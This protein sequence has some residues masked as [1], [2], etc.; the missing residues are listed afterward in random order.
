MSHPPRDPLPS[1]QRRVV[2]SLRPS[3]FYAFIN[4]GIHRYQQLRQDWHL[5][6]D[7]LP[8]VL[9]SLKG[10][11]R[12]FDGLICFVQ[13]A[14][15]AK[16]LSGIGLPVV[17]CCLPDQPLPFPVVG[18]DD[19]AVG[20]LAARHLA[21]KGVRCLVVAGGFTME[22]ARRRRDAF[23]AAAHRLGLP[24]R[25]IDH[26][27]RSHSDIEHHL[28]EQLV[29][30]PKPAGI[31]GVNDWEARFILQHCRSAGLAVPDEIA[32]LGAE[33]D[34]SLCEELVPALSSIDL[35]ADRIGYE[36]A[37]LLD[38]MIDG[39]RVND[40]FVSPGEL[41]LRQ[42]S[43]RRA[44]EDP[45]VT[46]ALRFIHERYGNRIQSAQVVAAVGVAPRTLFRRF[47]AVM[48][49][50]VAE[51]IRRVRIDKAKHLLRQ[52]HLSLAEIAEACGFPNAA[53]FAKTFLREAGVSPA[54]FR[55]S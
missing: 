36:A 38:R 31:F 13:N 6:D 22:F 30:L 12:P 42:S 26:G 11:R 43:N 33:N 5:F 41:V 23:H 54:H 25:T 9:R 34:P 17:N 45:V 20:D 35:A 51:E 10:G 3:L 28:V 50:G 40:V 44:I 55:R 37:K 29:A 39:E 16:P 19:A 49:W 48:G 2:V 18:P 4:R 47:S 1:A 27:A 21:D 7:P 15:E 46:H 32:V 52:T 14:E 53:Y 8:N 24:V